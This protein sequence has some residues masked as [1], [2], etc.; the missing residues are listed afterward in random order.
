M[1]NNIG[2]FFKR[3]KK[4]IWIFSV[5]LVLVLTSAIVFPSFFP[6]EESKAG[7][8]V[9]VARGSI[10]EAVD[11]VG[12]VEAEPSVS[13]VWE[14]AGVVADFTLEVGDEVEKGN[15]LMEL[16]GSTKSPEILQA[17]TSL[18]DAQFELDRLAASDAEFQ[19]VLKDVAYQELMLIHKYN[20][21]NAWNYGGSSDERIDAVLANYEFAER[22]LW[23]IEEQYEDLKDF[24]KDA[25]QRLEVYE[26][27]QDAIQERDILLRALNQILGHPYDLDVETDFI[28]YE[29]QDALVAQTRAQYRRLLDESEEIAAAQARVQALQ[30]TI[31]QARIITPIDGTV[32]EVFT[33]PGE[34]VSQGDLAV[35]IDDLSN[36]VVNVEISQ[37]DINDIRVG[38]SAAVVFEAVPNREY[39]GYVRE[40][41]E[42][43]SDESGEVKFRVSVKIENADEQVKPGFTALVQIITAEAEDALLV[44]NQ[45][46]FYD[47]DSSM[48]VLPEGSENEEARV[49]IEAGARSEAFTEVLSGEIDENDRLIVQMAGSTT[50]QV[51]SGQAI[52]EA[53]RINGGPLLDRK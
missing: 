46:I 4:T 18:L 35:Q 30:N 39:K 1:L 51:G 17:E 16:D 29:K 12:K 40:I 32:T 37:M 42:A 7:E 19:T 36:M 3:R 22:R 34:G 48:Y 50:F 13:I 28:A 21:R 6:S 43:G 52:I 14:S 33:N 24:E 23:E 53:H 2:I 49:Y 27:L 10:M 15:A 20:A 25:P 44:P 9:A 38:Q 26:E 31:D 41:S 45:A 5:L 47:E 8:V 11:A